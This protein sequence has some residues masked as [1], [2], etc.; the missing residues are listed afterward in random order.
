MVMWIIFFG[1]VMREMGA[2]EPL[3]R[4]CMML[5]TKVRHL[6]FW[7]AVLCI[8]G[9]MLLSDDQAQMATTVSYTHLDVYKRQQ[10][11]RLQY[12]QAT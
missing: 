4:L 5:S 11:L 7:N 1:G 12:V 9:N 2:F 6:M 8:I 3:A 10:D